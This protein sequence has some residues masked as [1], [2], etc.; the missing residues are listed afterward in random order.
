MA[1]GAVEAVVML[2]GLGRGP[3]SLR[4]LQEHLAQE[5]FWPLMWTYPTHEP[6]E[7][8]GEKIYEHLLAMDDDPAVS[9]VHAVGH[10]LGAIVLRHALS[11]GAPK[12]MGRVV[13]LAPPNQGSPLADVFMPVIGEAVQSLD[14]MRKK[15][16]ALVHQL[17]MPEGIE[18]GVIAAENDGK[19]PVESTHL[20]GEADHII[21]PGFHTWIM[22]RRDVQQYVS[23]FLRSGHFST[24]PEPRAD[25]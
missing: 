25:P 18:V 4:R 11:L 17:T 10:S 16:E 14:A 1:N 5:D 20:E 22:N 8:H 24:S 13:M 2:H 6:V 7:K 9:K 21:V 19:V 12:K 3:G 15:Q 23:S